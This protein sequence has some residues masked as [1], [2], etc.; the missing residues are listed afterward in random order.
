MNLTSLLDR[1]AGHQRQRADARKADFRKLVRQVA[2]G[3][4]PDAGTVDQVLADN[5]R[6]VDDLRTAVQ[7]LIERRRLRAEID[8]VPQLQKERDELERR[9]VTANDVLAQAEQLNEET[10]APLAARVDQIRDLLTSA[11]RSKE[12]LQ[13]TCVD[14]ELQAE[15]SE[16]Q[17]MLDELNT[18]RTDCETQARELRSAAKSDHD[19]VHFTRTPLQRENLEKRADRRDTKAKS[20]EHEAAGLQKQIIKTER[21]L[22]SLH[23]LMLEP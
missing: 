20:L 11:D 14:E 22:E 17:A 13:H 18:R 7:Q 10:L 16:L 8:R 15:R 12:K 6:T 4:E 23:E 1:I 3:T 21:R 5:R 19:E 2:D 9:I